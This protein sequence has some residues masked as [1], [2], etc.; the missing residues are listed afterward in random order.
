MTHLVITGSLDDQS[1][2]WNEKV[3]DAEYHGSRQ[4]KEKTAVGIKA[5]TAN[6]RGIIPIAA[7][8]ANGKLEPLETAIHE[9]LNGGLSISVT[10]RFT[11]R[12]SSPTMAAH[13]CRNAHLVRT[14][15]LVP[16]AMQIGR[17][18]V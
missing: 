17:A 6:Q 7:F 15:V 18:H 5:L 4:R 12:S 9:G 14:V 11:D 13:C 3:S 16:A 1:V 8:T 10:L 2:V